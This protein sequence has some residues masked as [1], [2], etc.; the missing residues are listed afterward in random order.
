MTEP[1]PA[2]TLRDLLA[3]ALDQAR[4]DL[5]SRLHDDPGAYLEL[6][7]LARDARTGTDELLRAA[8]VSARRAGCTWEQLGGVLGMTRQAVQQRFGRGIDGD[9][10]PDD[11]EPAPSVRERRRLAPV[12]AFSEMA[13]LRRLGRFGWHAV[14]YGA[15]YFEVEKDDHQWE[16]RR[17]LA[18]QGRPDGDGWQPVGAG[19]FPWAYFARRLGEPALVPP[20]GYDPFES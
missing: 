7:T 13:A 4:P 2:A 1:T 18:W 6:V 10:G 11:D 20:E 3:G 9:G 5:A 15:L 17:Q 12:T 16:H 19:W 8:V 14:W